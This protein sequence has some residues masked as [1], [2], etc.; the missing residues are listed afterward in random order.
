MKPT[1]STV[2]I[3]TGVLCLAIVGSVS[4]QVPD[5]GQ[6]ACYD[7]TREIACPRPG[8]PFYGQDAQYAG[9][10]PVYVDNGDGTITDR[11][12]GLTWQQIPDLEHEVTF[13]QAEAGAATFN[14][15]GHR[16]W[17][18]PT[19]KELYSLIDF[20]GSGK[21]GWP[22]LDTRYFAFRYGDPD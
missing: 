14:L 13:D 4:A 6:T 1:T 5:T 7:D 10:R 16:D 15:A 22:Y 2:L 18:L 19:I 8:E 11:A 20:R 12:T 9:T 17:R 21:A 3:L